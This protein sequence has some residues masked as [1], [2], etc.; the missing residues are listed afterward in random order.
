[1]RGG[2]KGRSLQVE[3]GSSWTETC[4]SRLR[5]KKDPTPVTGIAAR[6]RERYDTAAVRFLADK[7]LKYFL[8]TIHASF[9]A[10]VLESPGTSG[11]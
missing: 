7:N 5:I 10:F 11:L 2:R 6:H 3:K 4:W 1:M 9:C 8:T